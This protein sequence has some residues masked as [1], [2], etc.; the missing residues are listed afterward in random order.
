MKLSLKQFREQILATGLVS[1][2]ELERVSQSF[3]SPIN[4]TDDL[5]TA[6]TSAGKLT[7]FQTLAIANGKQSRLFLGVYILKEQIGA[8]GMGEVFLAEHSRMK[9][10]VV[11]KVLP[12]EVVEN[13]ESVRRFHREV[14][15]AAQLNHRNIVT[16]YDANEENGVHFYVMEYVQGRDLSSLVKEKGPLSIDLALKVILQ[17][18]EGLKYA[19][20]K[21]I[22]HRDIKPGN[23][24][25][26]N[27]GTIK[28]LDMG[29]A[30]IETAG[31][32][33][34][35]K[36]L[37]DSGMVMG[38]VDY[39]APEQ[40]L[41]THCAD[42][43]SDIYSLGCTLFYL[44]TRLPLFTETTV[45][46]KLMAHQNQAPPTLTGRRTDVPSEVESLY[47][48]M[49][50]KNPDDR[51]QSMT[52]VISAITKCV[53]PVGSEISD[54]QAKIADADMQSF[55]ENWSQE[56]TPAMFASG[57]AADSDP[58]YANTMRTNLTGDTDKSTAPQSAMIA[59]SNRGSVG[60]SGRAN[61]S[62]LAWVA[63]FAGIA[64]ILVI[65]FFW[66][67]NDPSTD[68]GGSPENQEQADVRP[69]D[70]GPLKDGGSERTNPLNHTATLTISDSE[71]VSKLIEKV[72]S[73]GGEVLC[74]DDEKQ[75]HF[76]LNLK[77]PMP[78]EA[79]FGMSLMLN[80]RED[81]ERAEL[82]ELFDLCRTV[83]PH[84]SLSLD[85]SRSQIA[86]DD[87]SSM[88]GLSF[89]TVSLDGNPEINDRIASVLKSVKGLKIL[90]LQ[91]TAVT[92]KTV[93]QL[94]TLET[95]EILNLT[96]THVTAQSRATLAQFQT[97]QKLILTGTDWD[98]SSIQA[99]QSDL[100]Q[101]EILWETGGPDEPQNSPRPEVELEE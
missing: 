78:K 32:A 48:N 95:L 28:I 40:A 81:L 71:T 94:A 92:D 88:A 1:A 66:G 18:A 6:L 12:Q 25:L 19:H 41:D 17:V 23:L 101:C 76:P 10:D 77:S 96:Q 24:L 60:S 67:D 69:G 50:A 13:P 55:L 22:V 89:L 54:S 35:G 37:T 31:D 2:E 3:G 84:H 79:D 99:L 90:G 75:T 93:E 47:R 80:D 52:E 64:L 61:S 34:D 7:R 11:L 44:L 56:T 86:P 63:G 68:P 57:S 20:E 8:G 46:K 74:W 100:P 30:R 14:H 36:G 38:T 43:R 70:D 39:M 72:K 45:M 62:M 33:D 53:A 21:G 42:A 15:A 26:D 97:L 16:A 5:S 91:E 58:I 87:L 83:A 85:L 65:A 4:S 27:S 59:E 98:E 82:D 73:L 29:L 9:R 51:F 49:V